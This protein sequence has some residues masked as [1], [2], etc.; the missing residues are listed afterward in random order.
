ML[1]LLDLALTEWHLPFT[2]SMQRSVFRSLELSR[3][4]AKADVLQRQLRARMQSIFRRTLC[5][6]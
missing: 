3:D 6:C 2:E 4:V 5:R 1:Q